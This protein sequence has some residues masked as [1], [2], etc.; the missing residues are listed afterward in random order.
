L[1]GAVELTRASHKIAAQF[2]ALALRAALDLFDER[3]F[4]KKFIR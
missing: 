1:G 2:Y 4:E 3:L